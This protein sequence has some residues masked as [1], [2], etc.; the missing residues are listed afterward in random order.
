MTNAIK[1][2]DYDPLH[3]YSVE[4]L[5]YLI[6]RKANIFQYQVRLRSHDLE[7]LER[8]NHSLDVHISKDFQELIAMKSRFYRY[9]GKDFMDLKFFTANLI[10]DLAKEDCFVR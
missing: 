1:E 9:T 2:K 4:E 6:R 7:Y 5:L 3:P 8:I 10:S